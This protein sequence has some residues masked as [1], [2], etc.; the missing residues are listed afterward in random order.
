MLISASIVLYK[1]DV[2]QLTAA[3]NSYAPSKNR[4]LYII[5][6]SPVKTFSLDSLGESVREYVYYHFLGVNKGYGA[7]HNTAIKMAVDLK[8]KYHLV[9]NPDVEFNSAIIDKIAQFMET[10]ESIAQVMPA[11]FNKNGEL[12]YL[13]KLLPSPA[14][15]FFKRFLPKSASKKILMRY[16]L[17]FA[18]YN[19]RMNPPC[20]SGC[21]MFFRTSAFKEAGI[22]DERFFMY[23]E[24]IDITRRMHILY[25][26]IYYPDVSIIHIH[27]AESYKSLSMFI[28]HILSIIK[29]FNKW[30]WFFDKERTLINNNFLENGIF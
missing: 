25:K 3:V 26:T 13:C 10:D 16:Q 18:D 28:A 12:Q 11:V 22:F 24:D 5:D 19:R 2:R 1:T 17:K 23:A 7:G 29:Y 15:L 6:N 20:L 14:D 30:G 4:I 9:L 8:S 21:F 27:K